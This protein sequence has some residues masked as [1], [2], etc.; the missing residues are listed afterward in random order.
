MCISTL[1]YSVYM[2]APGMS[3]VATYRPFTAAI[4]LS[5]M[6]DA[7]EG[8]EVATADIPGAFLQTNYDKGDIYIKLEGDMVTLFEDIDPKYYKYFIYTYIRGRKCMYAEIQEG[9]Q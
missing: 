7:T 5:C 2:K 8:R 6:L 3:T 9:Y 4:M 1:S